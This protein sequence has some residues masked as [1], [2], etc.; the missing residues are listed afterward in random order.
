VIATGRR[1]LVRSPERTLAE[2][3]AQVR[4]HRPRRVIFRDPTFALDRT[5]TLAL[6]AAMAALPGASR[7]PFEVESRPECLDGE[8]LAALAAAGCVEIKLGVESLEVAPLIA[9]R[10]VADAEAAQRYRAAVTGI[11]K[12]CATLGLILRIYLL[13]GLPGSSAA[14]DEET[15]RW[16]GQHRPR[17][18]KELVPPPIE[19]PP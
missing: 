14:G 17:E 6:L 15:E 13:H 18:R 4:R 3:A 7:C 5:G 2:F 10:R 12:T 1:H 16:L 8:V 9:A 11:M 19:V